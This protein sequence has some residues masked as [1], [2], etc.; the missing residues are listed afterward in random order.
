MSSIFR[1][2]LNVLAHYKPG[3]TFGDMHY[4][5]ELQRECEQAGY[6]MSTTQI[7]ADPQTC[8]SFMDEKAG[9]MVTNKYAV[10][11]NNHD[12]LMTLGYQYDGHTIGVVSIAYHGGSS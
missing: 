6:T 4:R 2:Q 9:R 7:R 3:D 8:Q 1:R 10:V 5:W 12:G 11:L